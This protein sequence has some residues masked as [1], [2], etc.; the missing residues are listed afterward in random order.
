[1]A[2]ANDSAEERDENTA[3]DDN[4]TETENSEQTSNTE[5]EQVVRDTNSDTKVVDSRLD[6]LETMMQRMSGTLD[7]L[8]AA[9]S[10]LIDSGAIIDTAES[11]PS[12]TDD[13]DDFNNPDY[14]TL[15]LR[16]TD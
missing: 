7:T 6:A 3:S 11:D 16:I 1:M 5:E 15:D 9:Q 2:D 10:V 8:V 14:D 13:V 4:A 12:D